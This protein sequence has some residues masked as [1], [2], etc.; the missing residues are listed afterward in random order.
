VSRALP[1]L[2][3]F[4]IAVSVGTPV[5]AAFSVPAPPARV[6]RVLAATFRAPAPLRDARCVAF[7]ESSFRRTAVS[8]TSDYGLFQINYRWHRRSGET[9]PAFATRMFDL[10]GNVRYA[11][12]L[13]RGG[14]DW[15]A[16]APRTRAAC[17]V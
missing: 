16:W 10:R 12:R 13:S 4:T 14:H 8:P 5:A 6:A 2:A 1:L 9:R 17:G 15:H 11:A 3:A 7:V